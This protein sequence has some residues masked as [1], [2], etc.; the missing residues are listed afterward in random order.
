MNAAGELVDL[1]DREFKY[2]TT[3]LYER[4]GIH[5]GDQKR[6][7]V[8]GRLSKRLHQL[9]LASFTQYIDYLISDTT[10]AE[11][12]E[13]I[14]RITTNHS[15][16]FREREHFDF[17]VK[18]VF[19]DIEKKSAS[20]SRYPL[21]I[22]SAGCATGE[23][24][25]SLGMLL[26]EHFKLKLD[27]MDYGLLAS[28]IS[29][30]ALQEASKGKYA[31]SKLTE[32]PVAYRQSYFTRIDNDM[33]AIKDEIKSMV[34]FK[35]LNLMADSYPLHG[36]FDAIFCRNVM[37][38]F[39]AASREKVVNTMFR[40]VKPG[41]YFFIGHSESLKRENCLFQYIK[42]AIYRKGES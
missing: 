1:D 27:S 8:S 3:M 2:L 11:L 6:I 21:R 23:E 36:Q 26:R 19:P 16:F 33:Y 20:H 18:T 13:M 31:A 29:L 42:P 9:G 25:F 5:L 17:L 7:L 22:W 37:I 38:Y 35:R 10:G 24:V 4:F 30:A 32:L 28:D 41:G 14:N 12:S 15:F 39:D 40:Y 34:L